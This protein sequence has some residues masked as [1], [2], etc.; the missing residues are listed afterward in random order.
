MCVLINC[1]V[2]CL[3]T[4]VCVKGPGLVFCN[5]SI[6]FLGECNMYD[7]FFVL[8]VMVCEKLDNSL[9]QVLT[10]TP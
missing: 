8:T 7:R 6:A 10:G 5:C 4:G 3:C 1:L 2:C 9:E